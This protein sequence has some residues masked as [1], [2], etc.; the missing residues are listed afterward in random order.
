MLTEQFHPDHPCTNLSYGCYDTL[1]QPGVI[2]VR[3]CRAR[4][5]CGAC[6]T[7]ECGSFNHIRRSCS[8]AGRSAEH[9]AFH[10]WMQRT[11]QSAS[12][13]QAC[14]HMLSTRATTASRGDMND[15]SILLARLAVGLPFAYAHFNEGEVRA[16]TQSTGHV[17]SRKQHYSPEL[18][19]A[20]AQA[21]AT[22]HPHF[23]IG[24]PCR[25]EFPREYMSALKLTPRT[26]MP[27]H[28]PATLFINGNYKPVGSLL[29]QLLH[30]RT[31]GQGRTGSLHLVVSHAA[32]LSLFEE[33]TGLQ[34]KTVHR[35]PTTDAF[36]A[37]ERLVGIDEVFV[38]GDVIILCAGVLGRLL[39]A[40]WVGRRPNTTFLELGSFFTP[41]LGDTRLQRYHRDSRWRPAC[42]QYTDVSLD[43]EVFAPMRECLV[44]LSERGARPRAAT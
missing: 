39:T 2:W 10:H 35:V 31:R 9:N 21:F 19:A 7:V 36:S 16:A 1:E 8:C 44:Q 11:V 33:R 20:M 37:L 28:T 27:R 25:V 43:Q 6:G 14:E 18:R 30:W 24:L 3:M 22:V 17:P 12:R 29:P 4:F 15:V 23:Y 5:Q 41:E 34:P 26:S 13:G 38:G 42:S 40:K 32:N